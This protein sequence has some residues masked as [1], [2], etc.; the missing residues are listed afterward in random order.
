MLLCCCAVTMAKRG[1]F[2]SSD[3]NHRRK[4]AHVFPWNKKSS[5]LTGIV[6]NKIV[7]NPAAL[8]PTKPD[9]CRV[10]LPKGRVSG[11]KRQA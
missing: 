9:F 4:I 11:I 8:I 7:E 10:G 1:I 6:F 3:C 5:N 2:M